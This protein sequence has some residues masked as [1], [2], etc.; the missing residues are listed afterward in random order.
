MNN[1]AVLWYPSDFIGSTSLWDNEQCGAYIRLLNLQFIH[2]HLSMKQITKITTD[3]EVLE[4]FVKDDDG[5]Y[6]NPRMEKEIEKRKNYCE[7]RSKNKLGKTKNHM[8][9]ISSSYVE[10]YENHMGNRNRNRNINRNIYINN[11][12]NI[13][14]TNSNNIDNLEYLIDYFQSNIHF[15]TE[16]EYKDLLKWREVFS[17][18]MII[19]AIDESILR[20]VKNMKYINAILKDWEGKGYK[21]PSDIEDKKKGNNQID[22]YSEDE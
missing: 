18:E 15:L 14:N 10:T 11:T 21:L 6:Y 8:K 9:N 1:P 4:K 2:G 20:N 7:S 22:W 12:N 5:F 13:N 3:E 17:N 19:K 16:R